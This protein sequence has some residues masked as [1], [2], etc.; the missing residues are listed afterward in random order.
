M[1]QNSKQTDNTRTFINEMPRT[2]EYTLFQRVR[3]RADNIS[4]SQKQ[5]SENSTTR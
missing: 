3:Q 2:R 1:R 5:T 4:M